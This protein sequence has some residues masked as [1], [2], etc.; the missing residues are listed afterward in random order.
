MLIGILVPAAVLI[1]ARKGSPNLS[2]IMSTVLGLALFVIAQL[3]TLSLFMP[4]FHLGSVTG[5]R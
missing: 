4:I 2:V 1:L 5:E 3:I